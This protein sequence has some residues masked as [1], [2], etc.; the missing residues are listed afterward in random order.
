MLA[1]QWQRHSAQQREPQ[2]TLEFWDQKVE[3]R[4]QA[5]ANLHQHYG[6]HCVIPQAETNLRRGRELLQTDLNS[7]VLGLE[8]QEWARG[9][10]GTG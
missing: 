6:Y 8:L 9:G 10:V 2:L 7:Y 1:I 5:E 4:P 3:S